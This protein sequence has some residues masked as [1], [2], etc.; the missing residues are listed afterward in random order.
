MNAPLFTVAIPICNG[1]PHIA[2]ALKSILAQANEIPFNLIIS[3]DR[4]DDATVE[5]VRALAGNKA[6]IHQNPTRLG[7][8]GNWNQCLALTE[9][10]FVTIFHQDDVMLSGH[11]RAHADAF[12]SNDRIGLVSSATTVID[13]QNNAIPSTV[14]SAAGLGPTNRVF[15]PGELAEQMTSGNPLRCSAIS[16]RRGPC[17]E[18]G[19]FDPSYRYVLDWD[20]WLRVSRRWSVAWLADPTVQIRWHPSSETHRFKTGTADLDETLRLM[21]ELFS[22]DLAA[23]PH[24]AALH[25]AANQSLARAF[26]NR[27]LV[28]LQANQPDLAR[29]ALQRA[30]RLSPRVLQTILTDPRLA[31]QMSALVLNPRLATRWFAR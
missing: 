4:S 10:P 14:V 6:I 13:A 11:L 28:A 7:L 1:Q 30:L 2:P 3:D 20:Y 21:D 22:R 29:E 5:E 9:T 12:A 16:L 23:H 31:I 17:Q 24:K 27:A 19:Q 25:R 26:L 18:V 8:A 15:A